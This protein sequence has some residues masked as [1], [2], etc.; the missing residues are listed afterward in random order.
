[1]PA[2]ADDIDVPASWVP[3]LEQAFGG[4]PGRFHHVH[5][6]WQRAVELRRFGLPWIDGQRADRLELAALLHDIGRAL[7]PTDAEPH[8]FVGARFLDEVGLSAIAPLVAHHSGACH[9]AAARGM[10]HLDRWVDDDPD[11]AVV[12]TYLDRTTSPTGERVS[13]TARRDGLV[14]RY[15]E[16]SVQVTGFDATLPELRPA[17]D[18]VPMASADVE[19]LRR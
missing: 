14:R 7:D 16:E 9:E 5:A 8:G 1:M 12:L 18:L 19:A 13:L 15:G 6:V 17:I 11:L 3:W 4:S 10:A 2:P